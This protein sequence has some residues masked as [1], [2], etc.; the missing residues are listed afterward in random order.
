ML[1]NFISK[2][3][4]TTDAL[5]NTKIGGT[6][7]PILLMHGYPQTHLM[8]HKIAPQLSK[9]FT[10]IVTDLRG[11]GDSS[12]PKTDN[13][14]IVYSKKR[15]ALDQVEVMKALGFEKFYAVGHDRGARVLHRMMI[16]NQNS[17]KK[18]VFMDIVPTLTM[19]NTA[20]KNFAY[21]Y[22]H[23]FFLTQPYDFPERLIGGN[24]EYYLRKKIKAWGKNKDFI[25]KE[26]FNEYL[27]C[28]SK[29]ET[30]HASC[31]DYRASFTIDL[32]HDKNDYG[33]KIK[34]PIYVMWGEYGFV[35][36]NYKVIDVW[37]E[38]ATNVKGKGLPCGHYIPE[39]S[40]GETLKFLLEF[41]NEEK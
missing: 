3:I 4:K 41:L 7:P 31:E 15:M 40:P 33:N 6:G 17:V 10:V 22:Y 23:W 30:I 9:K 19:Y 26:V 13:S 34:N 20:D 8:W 32:E 1:K 5:I 14:H 29:K 16:D 21:N 39:E 24:P 37:K 27:R 18:A 36:N 25:P 2:K 28:F 11:Y 12:K 35:G 38:Y